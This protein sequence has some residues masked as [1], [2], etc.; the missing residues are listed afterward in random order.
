MEISGHDGRPGVQGEAGVRGEPG[1]EKEEEFS[2][3]KI[4]TIFFLYFSAHLG[5][6]F[7]DFT[8]FL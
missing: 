3:E 6:N 1:W 2:F 4:L 5:K 8:R 7:V